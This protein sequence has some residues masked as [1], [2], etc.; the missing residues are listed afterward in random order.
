MVGRY[1]RPSERSAAPAR[2]HSWPDPRGEWWCSPP[3]YSAAAVCELDRCECDRAVR[4]WGWGRAHLVA[5]H[6]RDLLAEVALER[7]ATLD[8]GEKRVDVGAAAATAH[9]SIGPWVYHLGGGGA[10]KAR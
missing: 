2:V 1:S 4:E 3:S 9:R 7:V 8:K 5:R 10:W 6:W